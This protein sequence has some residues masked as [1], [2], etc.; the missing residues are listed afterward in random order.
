MLRPALFKALGCPGEPGL[1]D[2]LAGTAGIEEV[3]RIDPVSGAHFIPA[4][5]GVANASDLLGG[6]ALRLLLAALRETYDLVVIDSPPVLAVSDCLVLQPLVDETLFIVRW[7]ETP[8]VIVYA[9]LDQLLKGG[10]PLSGLVMTQVDMRKHSQYEFGRHGDA[11]Y[12]AYRNYHS[13]A[14]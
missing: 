5:S 8:Q 12:G 1:V 3:V 11:H 2:Y 7:R 4:G 13:D 10:G 6:T 14:A 9:A